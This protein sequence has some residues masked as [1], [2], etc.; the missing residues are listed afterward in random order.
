MK[1]VRIQSFSGPY[2]PAFG[3]NTSPYLVRIRENTDQQNSEYGHFSRSKNISYLQVIGYMLEQILINTEAL[4]QRCSVKRVFL[5]F[6]KKHLY[7]SLFFNKVV[8]LRPI[9]IYLLQLY[10]KQVYEPSLSL[11]K[12]N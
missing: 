2:F 10:L 9:I 5:K 11:I 1:S 4:V 6:S 12:T 7:Q 8:G 3:L